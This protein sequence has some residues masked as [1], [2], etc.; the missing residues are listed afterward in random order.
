[1]EDDAMAA[2]EKKPGSA[3]K[4]GPAGKPGEKPGSQ[5]AGARKSVTIDLEAREVGKAAAA[6]SA[7][8]KSEASSAK[9]SSA[10]S[11]APANPAKEKPAEASKPEAAKAEDKKPE[12]AGP[13]S[14]KQADQP[15]SPPKDERPAP[16]KSAKPAD[17]TAKA[18]AEASPPA[19][20][21]TERRGHGFGGLLA[22][23]IVGAA[24]VAAAG[25][26]LNQAGYLSSGSGAVDSEL[27]SLIDA[28]QTRVA[29]LESRLAEFSRANPGASGVLEKRLADLENRV[30]SGTNE[31]S[32]ALSQEI[33]KL[34][35]GLSELRRFVS[36]GNAGETAGLASLQQDQETLKS[37]LSELSTKFEALQG[38]ASA[39]ATL[40]SEASGLGDRLA[41]TEAGTKA[42][43]ETA[44]AL[45]G[46]LE[47]LSG[48]VAANTEILA[49]LKADIAA[50]RNRLEPL[51][52]RVGDATAREVAARALAVAALQTA[53]DAGRP[54]ATELAALSATLP[55]E[56][57]LSALSAH[58]E[59]GVLSASRLIA[60]FPAS[61][62]AMSAALDQPAGDDL[63][64]TFLSNARSLVNVRRLDAGDGASPE[65]ALARM[66]ASVRAGDLDAALAA[67]DTL[68]E[69]ARAAGADWA[70]NA[71]ARVE[72]EKLAGEV[73]ATVLQG[74]GS[75]GG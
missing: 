6:A 31:A 26:G 33:D 15:S 56:K 67:Y 43:Q 14:D 29:E 24:V 23:G 60:G 75:S 42:A 39:I 8:A 46:R 66:E 73:A 7:G 47:E 20:E 21:T 10:A 37:S 34:G 48:K 5:A 16:E 58:A 54:Y 70:G 4:S 52:S 55:Q 30:S 68:P 41:A 1:M 12:K 65:A 53:L 3:S 40:Q 36:S 49:G 44:A 51:E 45:A 22:A 2:D 27:R 72:A 63:V 19:E 57:D 28:S 74:L 59:S 71:R 25:Y 64:G 61:A 69:A 50:V 17:S 62:R 13:E 35:Q 38:Q 32:Q 9:P 11:T 18:T